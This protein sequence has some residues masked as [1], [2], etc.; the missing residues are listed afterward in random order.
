MFTGRPSK[1]DCSGE[2]ERSAS[3]V[4]ATKRTNK[5]SSICLNIP[6]VGLGS[7]PPSIISTD[8]GGFNEPSPEIKAKLKPS[9]TF[10]PPEIEQIHCQIEPKQQYDLE[11]TSSSSSPP[12]PPL[13]PPSTISSI[14]S[15]PPSLADYNAHTLHYVDFGYRLNPD[16]SESR[17][18]FG[19]SELYRKS[20][21]SEHLL[22]QQ[23]IIKAQYRSTTSSSVSATNGFAKESTVLYATIKPEVPPPTDLFLESDYEATEKIYH[24]PQTI[25]DPTRPNLLADHLNSTMMVGQLPEPPPRPPLPE[26][27][28]LDI[29]DVEYADASDKEDYLVED[30][31][32]ADEAERLLS[33]R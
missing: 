2:L 9:Y 26:G 8:E 15:Q 14:A 22:E 10:D 31:M 7:R 5:V 24:S 25:L 21:D 32:T 16:G 11:T 27:P 6:A 4:S 29:Q 30:M 20:S 23:E 13:P 33:S 19:E 12:P 28:P 3:N 1:T 17:Q 18:I